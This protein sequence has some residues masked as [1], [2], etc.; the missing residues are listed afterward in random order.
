MKQIT[1]DYNYLAYYDYINTTTFYDTYIATRSGYESVGDCVAKRPAAT[2]A[3][4]DTAFY[5]GLKT[6]AKKYLRNYS[7]HLI[8][9]DGFLR[10]ISQLP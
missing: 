3:G 9:R 6:F 10:F 2:T 7:M 4:L 8:L 1:H 5:D